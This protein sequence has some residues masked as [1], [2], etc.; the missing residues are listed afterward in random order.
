M[1]VTREVSTEKAMK[2]AVAV[3]ENGVYRN[4]ESRCLPAIDQ[5]RPGQ[6]LQAWDFTDVVTEIVAERTDLSRACVIPERMDQL[7]VNCRNGLVDVMT[8]ELLPHDPKVLTLFQVPVSYDPNA[9]CPISMRTGWKNA[10]RV[11]WMAL[12]DRLLPRRWTCTR[13]PHRFGF[14]LGA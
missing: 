10:Y 8:G 11:R 4:G 6:L 9:T 7:L 12:E 1:A 5:Q 14:L 2:G 3:Y 13:T